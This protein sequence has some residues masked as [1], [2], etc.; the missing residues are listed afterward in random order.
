MRKLIIIFVVVVILFGCEWIDSPPL[1][2]SPPENE[3][4][5]PADDD[6]TSTIPS[7]L[8]ITSITITEEYG[9][10]YLNVIFRNDGDKEITAAKFYA[11][12]K[13]AFG[14]IDPGLSSDYFLGYFDSESIASGET[15][16]DPFVWSLWYQD[17]ASTVAAYGVYEIAFADGSTWKDLSFTP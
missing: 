16:P 13:D 17:K 1:P 7:P 5:P 2:D 3:D 8:V 12:L 4:P 6:Q 15:I 10:K 11:L 14:E 9:Y